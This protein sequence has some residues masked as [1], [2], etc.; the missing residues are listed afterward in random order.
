M[1][2]FAHSIRDTC[3]LQEKQA[4]TVVPEHHLVSDVSTIWNSICAM[5]EHLL[6]Q[7][8]ALYAALLVTCIWADGWWWVILFQDLTH[9]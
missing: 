3:L 9:S 2:H 7:Q 1:S 8:R 5:L 6:E 4:L